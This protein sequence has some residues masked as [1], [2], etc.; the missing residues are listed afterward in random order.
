MLTLK[1]K[2][3]LLFTFVIAFV[4]LVSG[5]NKNDDSQAVANQK[6]IDAAVDSVRLAVETDIGKIV[7]TLN[8]FIETPEGSWFSS[9]AGQG[10]QPITPD[11]YFRFASNTKTF[12]STAILNMQEDGW[13][14]IDD[15]ITDTIPGSNLPYVPA[16]DAWNIPYKGEITIKML[17]QHSAGVYDVDNDSVPACNGDSYTS[18]MMALDQ[19][20]QFTAEEMVGQAAQHQLSYFAP[21]TDHHYSNTGFV[22]LS[23]IAGRVYS[24]HAGSQKH[25]SDYLY[26]KITGPAAIVPI[27]AHFPYQATDTEMPSPF[28]CGHFLIEPDNTI[29]FCG[30]NMS[31]QIGE[32]NGYA[33]M[34][35]L[36]TFIR[37]LIKGQNVLTQNTI[38]QMT[39]SWSPGNN[40]YALGCL[41][42]TNLGYGHNGA[43]IGNLSIMVYDPETDVSVI[44]YIS[45]WE[46]P[47][48]MV[49]IK[50]IYSA[51]YS[52]RS[53]LGY[54]GEPEK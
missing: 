50:A 26:D 45:A 47:D 25:L 3:T 48:V 15:L 9:S 20:H 32:G 1:F 17:L 54:P 21:G 37:T 4:F 36:N 27:D 10:Y 44:S 53:A 33:T 34:R 5:C 12:T 51:A 30:F 31:G 6:K 14:N 43:R 24:F 46:I 39:T 18:Y 7:P 13:L 29:A 2:K 38:Q 16:S 40:S 52:A 28:S 41:Y 8:V 49:T 42:S 22:I 11:T 19:N 35:G 23:E